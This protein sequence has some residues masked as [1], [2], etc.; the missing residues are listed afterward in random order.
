MTGVTQP[1]Q[2]NQQV[3]VYTGCL[4]PEGPKAFPVN[5]D[6]TN[7]PEFDLDLS[8]LQS[9]G[10][11]SQVQTVF[12]DN[13]A[14][15]A[16]VDFVCSVSLQHIRIPGNTQGYVNIL[17]PNPPKFKF[18]CVNPVVVPIYFLNFFMPPDI[19]G[20]GV[21]NPTLTYTR[22]TGTIAAGGVSQAAVPV[23]TYSEVDIYN[24][25]TETE[26]LFVGI[27]NPADD[28]GT[29]IG[30][31]PGKMLVVDSSQAINLT[32]ATPGHKFVIEAGF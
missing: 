7:G 30:I 16:P 4:P 23:N 17:E 6:F 26:D 28:T 22:I 24:P 19:W 9:Q 1:Q 31:A 27:G 32:A 29:S 11:I 15:A 12:V 18:T 10:F 3:S 13:S 8:S 5:A 20:T 21:A 14:N 2:A 25:D